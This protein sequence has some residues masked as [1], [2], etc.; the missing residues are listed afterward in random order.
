MAGKFANRRWF[1][2]VCRLNVESTWKPRSASRVAGFSAWPM[3]VVPQRFRAVSQVAND[4]GVPT[5]TPLVT[6][7]GVKL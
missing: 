2:L 6:S 3:P 5:E 1:S 7:S 4:P